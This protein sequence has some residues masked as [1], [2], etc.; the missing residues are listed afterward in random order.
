MWIL[1]LKGSTEIIRCKLYNNTGPSH[2]SKK[3]FFQVL[4]LQELLSAKL[5]EFSIA[6]NVMLMNLFLQ[7]SFLS[8]LK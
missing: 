3:Y 7:C 4:P 8:S 6:H 5:S 2:L 1:G